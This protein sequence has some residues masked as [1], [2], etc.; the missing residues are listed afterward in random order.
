MKFQWNS[1]KKMF[2]YSYQ[3]LCKWFVCT[4]EKF[5]FIKKLQLLFNLKPGTLNLTEIETNYPNKTLKN[6]PQ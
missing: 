4:T 2:K 1:L 3:I 6:V 5:I